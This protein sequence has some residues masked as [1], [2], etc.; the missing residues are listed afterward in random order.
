MSSE[1]SGKINFKYQTE[2]Y[3]AGFGQ[4]I[5]TTPMQHIQ[6]LTSIANDGIMLKP[7]IID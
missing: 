2:V 6:A 3:N 4:G 5:T 7:Y 1:V